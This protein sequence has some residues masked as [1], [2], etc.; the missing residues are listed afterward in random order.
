MSIE[1]DT[2]LLYPSLKIKAEKAVNLALEA[3]YDIRV[4]ETYRSPQRQL[5]LRASRDNVTKASAWGSWHQYGLAFDVAFGGEGKWHW[6][7]DFQ[8]L[9]PYF[10]IEGIVWGGQGDAGHYQY[11]L[12]LSI[13][14]AIKIKDEGGVLGVWQRIR[15]LENERK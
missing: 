5:M 2:D 6:N 8:A 15:D 10:A 9:V 13:L 14:H 4:F 1:R 7:G 12:G 3:G 11:N